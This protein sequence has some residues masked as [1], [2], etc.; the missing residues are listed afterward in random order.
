MHGADFAAEAAA[1]GAA[2]L[3]T[4][5][6]GADRARATGLP[7]V[8]ADDPRALLGA[9]AA[10]L[11]GH[12]ARS[13]DPARRHRH[14]RQDHHGVPARRR[15]AGRRPRTGLLGTVLTRVGDEVVPSVRTTPEA[16]DLQAL[17]AVMRERGVH[18][19][20]DGGEQPRAGARPGR[21]GA[22]RAPAADR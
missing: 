15:A 10:E 22:G 9:T 21:R 6:A 11:H 18:G 3:L 19:G 20:G 1:A 8:L 2:A 16:P 5:A 7:V 4:D 17:L 13:A 12:P 14:E